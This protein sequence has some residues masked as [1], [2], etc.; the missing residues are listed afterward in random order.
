LMG[1]LVAAGALGALVATALLPELSSHWLLL[2]SASR[3]AMV[4]AGVAAVFFVLLHAVGVEGTSTPT[5]VIAA[6][7]AYLVAGSVDVIAV[8][9]NHVVGERLPP[10]GRAGAMSV[11]GGAFQ[12]TQAITIA[13]AGLLTVWVP[14]ALVVALALGVGVAVSVWSAWHP[15]DDAAPPEALEAA[16]A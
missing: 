4:S 10:Q 3:R 1:L 2:R 13:L 16:T 14:V 8:Q 15:L 11:A 7:V 9:T 6:I 12:G 5:I